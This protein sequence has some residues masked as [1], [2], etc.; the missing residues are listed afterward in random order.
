MMKSFIRLTA[1]V[2]LFLAVGISM[3]TAQE[4]T[5]SAFAPGVPTANRSDNGGFAWG[6]L[7]GDGVLDVMVPPNNIMIN[8]NAEVFR[9]DLTRIGTIPTAGTTTPIMLADF[10]GDGRLDLFT[11]NGNSYAN[12][13]LFIDSAGVLFKRPD[14][15][16]DLT[17]AGNSFSNFAGATAADIDHS[18]Y[19]SVAWAGADPSNKTTGSGNPSANGGGWWLLK[20]SATGFTHIGKGAASGN[21]GID[22]NLTYESWNPFFL[23]AKVDG[24]PDLMG[25]SL[26]N[27]FEKVNKTTLSGNRKGCV[28][29]VNDGTG[30]FIIPDATTLGRTIYSLD[31]VKSSYFGYDSL[32]YAGVRPDSGVIV[33]DTVRHFEAIANTHGDF[34]N[35]GIED[36]IFLSNSAVNFDAFYRSLNTVIIYGKG[37]G[38]YTWKWNGTNVV[39]A[40]GLY[41]QGGVRGM[42]LGDYNNDGYLDVLYSWN[43]NQCKLYRNNGDGSF[44]DV[45]TTDNVTISGTRAAGFADYNGDGF[46]DLYSYTGGSSNLHKS[47]GNSNHWVGFKPQANGMNSSAIGAKFFVYTQFGTMKQMHVVSAEAGAQG[48]GH[49]WLNFGVGTSTAIDSLVVKWPDGT[50]QSFNGATIAVDKYTTVKQGS[51]IPAVAALSTPVDAASGQTPALD[52][53]WAAATGALKYQVQVGLDNTFAKLIS[54]DNAN[55][56]GTSLSVV[57]GNGTTYYWRVRGIN[58]GFV[59][60]WSTVRSFTTAAGAPS[61]PAI[62][63]PADVAVNQ[64]NPIKLIVNTAAGASMYNWQVSTSNTFSTFA[65]DDTTADTTRSVT[66]EPGMTYYWKVRGVN[67]GAASAFT[68]ARSF[69]LTTLPA[70]PA[71]AYPA[72]DQKSMRKDTLWLKWRSVANASS[73]ECDLSTNSAFSSYLKPYIGDRTVTDTTFKIVGLN[74]ITKY[75]WRVRAVVN[76]GKGSYSV[77]D[78]FTTIVPVPGA[79]TIVSPNIAEDVNRLTKFIWKPILY[80]EKYHLQV[81]LTNTYA[82]LVVDTTVK[83]GINDTTCLLTSP[84]ASETAY[85]WRVAAIDTMGQGA[86]SGNGSFT[87]GIKN[88]VKAYNVIPKAFTLEQ[89][90][91][92]P[93][94]PSTTIRYDLA[95]ASSVKL[96]VYDILGRVVANLVNENQAANSYKVDW[97]ASQL[98]SGIYFYRIDARNQDGSMNFTSVKK[99]ILMK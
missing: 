28:Q 99:L 64:P 62:V 88:D 69:T 74:N 17:T 5:F 96:V 71:L 36:I 41:Q 90:Y 18:G 11:T 92:N 46:L 7:N 68:T 73:Y 80:A 34:N 66:L 56:S 22:T 84:L 52:L 8:N 9:Q 16:G 59:G 58:A 10:N 86:W 70:A 55:V 15:L 39:A 32:I 20:G 31:S 45:S 12:G 25:I 94:N 24:Y 75:F 57:L 33:D 48:A 67:Q 91:P 4:V 61:V 44:T 6:D 1:L 51:V 49:L 97:N 19:L 23:D 65:V 82:A 40:N 30:K 43:F 38:T 47:S 26:R 13:G 54:I 29:F 81:S 3:S 63:S 79:P 60:A 14:Q 50:S 21:L 42:D 27:A 2:M 87:T 35:D 98:S 77:V 76:S 95:K 53:S 37:D 85:F 72:S 83:G 93:F 89:N 78:S